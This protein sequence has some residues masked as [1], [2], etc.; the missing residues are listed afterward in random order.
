MAEAIRYSEISALT[1]TTQRHIREDIIFQFKRNLFSI[2]L[3]KSINIHYI[4]K[5]QI[6]NRITGRG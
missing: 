6:W 5:E 1:R 2:S 3:L 4:K